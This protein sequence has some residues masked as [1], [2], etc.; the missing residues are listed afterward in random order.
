MDVVANGRMLIASAS[1]I[2]LG[3]VLSLF[4]AWKVTTNVPGMRDWTIGF[5]LIGIG[6]IMYLVYG[7]YGIIPSAAIGYTSEIIGLVLVARGCGIFIFGT[8]SIIPE[9]IIGA[10]GTTSSALFATIVP[11]LLLR[12]AIG[13]TA[14]ALLQFRIASIFLSRQNR[15][16]RASIKYIS[17]ILIYIGAI[18]LI[19]VVIALFNHGQNLTIYTA[20]VFPILVQLGYIGLMMTAIHIVYARFQL[21][22]AYQVEERSILLKEMHHRTKNNLALVASL[23]S[24][25]SSQFPELEIS[26]AFNRLRTRIQTIASLH[27]Q[28]QHSEASRFVQVNEYLS[29]VLHTTRTQY[30]DSEHNV[31]II[32]EISEFAANSKSVITLGLITNELVTN[33]M[34]H[35]FPNHASGKILVRFSVDGEECEL[36]VEDD[37]VGIPE[38]VREGAL[39]MQLINALI[40]QLAG[41]M[42]NSTKPGTR[43]CITFPAPVLG[44]E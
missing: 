5:A 17:L 32:S 26:S 7:I 37:G 41:K 1:F 34:K 10:I 9:M 35:A 6:Q 14:L 44:K 30:A 36:V 16:T 27:E 15:T 33:A 20:P 4:L 13:N 12:M 29:R 2:Y 39:G 25:E 23:V 24:L 40:S 21:K 18:E 11:H 42:V 43:Y 28:L 19:Q 38:P 8:P 31:E 22:L 3:V